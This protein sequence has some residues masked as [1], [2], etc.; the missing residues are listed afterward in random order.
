LFDGWLDEIEQRVQTG[1]L[2]MGVGIS[3]IPRE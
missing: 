3:R 1:K 2:D